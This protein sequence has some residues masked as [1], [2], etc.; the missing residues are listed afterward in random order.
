MIGGSAALTLTGAP[1][2][3]PIGA[4]RVAFVDGNYV[5]NPSAIQLADSRLNLVVAGTRKAVLMV[6]SE[7]KELT[8]DEMLGAVSFGHEEMQVAIDSI[9]ELASEAG[10]EPWDWQAPESDTELEL[11]VVKAVESESDSGLPDRGES[12]AAGGA[13]QGS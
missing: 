13:R 1:F 4:A 7:A 6:E 11:K 10:T 12:S 8:E 9:I 5:L 3:G 2:N